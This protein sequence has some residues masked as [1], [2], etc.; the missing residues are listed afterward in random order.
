MYVE[1]AAILD[2]SSQN[3]PQFSW[4]NVLKSSCPPMQASLDHRCQCSEAF[5]KKREKKQK[6]E[7]GEKVKALKTK[8]DCYAYLS[9]PT[10][11]LQQV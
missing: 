8:T 11:F 4:E 6:C 7:W 1:V 9:M 2:Q 10:S 3:I 5:K